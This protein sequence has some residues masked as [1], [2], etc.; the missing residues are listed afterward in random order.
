MLNKRRKSNVWKPSKEELE[1]LVWSIP[2]I[3]IAK[4]FG[5]SDKAINKWCKSYN[6]NKPGRGYWTKQKYENHR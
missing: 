3:E 5:V 1:K 6:I 4:C 2:T